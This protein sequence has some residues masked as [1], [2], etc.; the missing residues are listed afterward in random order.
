MTAATAEYRAVTFLLGLLV[1][2]AGCVSQGI[3]DDSPEPNGLQS[4]VSPQPPD[5]APARGPTPTE[6][7]WEPYPGHGSIPYELW[8]INRDADTTYTV[9]IT[10]AMVDPRETVYENR[11]TLVPNASIRRNVEYPSAGR[12]VIEAAVE[13]GAT[14]EFGYVAAQPDPE[15]AVVFDVDENGT[16]SATTYN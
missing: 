6:T 11:F 9:A 15:N 2:S 3:A 12:Y 16:V 10:I 13:P 1:V 14:L 8:L 4:T 5:S 7:D